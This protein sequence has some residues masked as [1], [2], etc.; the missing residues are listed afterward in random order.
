MENYKGKKADNLFDA[1]A[2]YVSAAIGALAFSFS[3]TFWFNG[4][5]A[6]VYAFSTFLFCSC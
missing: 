4:V 5:E 3:D 6:E 1:I 2:T